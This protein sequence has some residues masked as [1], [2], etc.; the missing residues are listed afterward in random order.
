MPPSP[1]P[2]L[3]HTATLLVRRAR[4]AHVLGRSATRRRVHSRCHTLSDG[5]SYLLKDLRVACDDT[6]LPIMIYAAASFF[7]YGAGVATIALVG[8]LTA[9]MLKRDADVKDF[10]HLFPGH[11][12]ILDRLDSFFFVAPLAFGVLPRLAPPGAWVA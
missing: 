6:Y 3:P 9:S 11:G 7:V 12:G 10:G 2:E 5:N 1:Q 4:V 8:D